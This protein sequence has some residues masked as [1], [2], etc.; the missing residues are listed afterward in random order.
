MANSA[1]HPRSLK[2][3]PTHRMSDF[4]RSCPFVSL[5]PD[6]QE[7]NSESTP[8]RAIESLLS[9]SSRPRSGRFLEGFHVLA[10]QNF[11]GCRSTDCR[12]S[13]LAASGA[14]RRTTRQ[15][16]N[17]S[18]RI[19]H[20]SNRIETRRQPQPPSRT[21]RMPIARPAAA[22]ANSL[23]L[24]SKSSAAKQK[25]AAQEDLSGAFLLTTLSD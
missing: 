17:S 12:I 9:G 19:V 10:K 4:V 24:D 23:H 1:P 20:E 15:S 2:Q 6:P 22:T 14:C 21:S 13:S 18:K 3:R 25:G 8:D 11:Y 5:S 16:T 7:C